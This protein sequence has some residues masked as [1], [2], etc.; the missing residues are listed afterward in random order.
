MK[1]AGPLAATAA[2]AARWQSATCAITREVDGAFDPETGEYG[3]PTVTTIYDDACQ[4]L[5]VG[6]DRVVE[7][8]E[9]PVSLRQYDV[10]LTGLSEA[11]NVEDKVA[12]SS[13]D[14]PQ[15]DGLSLRVLDVPKSSLPTNRHLVCEEAQD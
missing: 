8:G 13:D 5:P 7:F 4:V 10:T 3:D 6:A 1:F 12:V 14:D 11:V 9:G 15:L 2:Y